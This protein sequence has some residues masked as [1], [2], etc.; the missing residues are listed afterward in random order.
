MLI[1]SVPGRLV[2]DPATRRKVDETPIDVDA[3][4]P[5]WVV[6]LRDGDVAEATPAAIAAAKAAAAAA[7][8]PAPEPTPTGSASKKDA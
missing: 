3:T 5:Y 4:D 1:V 8:D 6:M 2:R 7:A